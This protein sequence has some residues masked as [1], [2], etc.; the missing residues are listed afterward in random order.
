MG[1]DT[2]LKEKALK[3]LRLLRQEAEIDKHYL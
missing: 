1:H 3:A 2:E